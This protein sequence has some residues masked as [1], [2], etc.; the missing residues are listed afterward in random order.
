[1]RLLS[2][3]GPPYAVVAHRYQPLSCLSMYSG[4]ASPERLEVSV[5]HKV[6][7]ELVQVRPAAAFLGVGQTKLYELVNDGQLHPVKIGTRTLFAV[8]EL[9]A[10]AAELAQAAGVPSALYGPERIGA[11]A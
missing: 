1:M 4:V 10:L 8:R 3:G 11:T 5:E 6:V 7:P 9:R 2:G